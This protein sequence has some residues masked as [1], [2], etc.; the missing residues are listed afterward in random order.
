MITPNA[1]PKNSARITNT[2]PEKTMRRPY[3]EKTGETKT[4]K[5]PISFRPKPP[6][7]WKSLDCHC[8][9]QPQ[10]AY[11]QAISS[12]AWPSKPVAADQS[13]LFEIN[14]IRPEHP[15]KKPKSWTSEISSSAWPSKLATAYHELLLEARHRAP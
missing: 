5:P 2:A 7:Q 9:K 10:K 15:W 14:T 11:E 1:T 3:C 8:C 13:L 12:L 6:F 4:P